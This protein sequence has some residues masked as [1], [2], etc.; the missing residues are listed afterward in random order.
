[1]GS[2]QICLNAFLSASTAFA[3]WL[4][5]DIGPLDYCLDSSVLV[6]VG[7]GRRALVSSIV[8]GPGGEK[9]RCCPRSASS[10]EA[11]SFACVV[12]YIK[13]VSTILVSFIEQSQMLSSFESLGKA[14]A[15]HMK[16]TNKTIRIE[17]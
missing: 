8:E 5:Y 4:I 16:D 14:H 2:C 17:K 12:N 15:I 11:M 9:L 7:R 6:A 10:W 3:I 1:M 13:R